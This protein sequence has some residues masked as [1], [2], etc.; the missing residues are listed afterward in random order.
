[1]KT[2][3]RPFN[4]LQSCQK[5]IRDLGFLFSFN[6]SVLCSVWVSSGRRKTVAETLGII[7]MFQIGRKGKG[8]GQNMAV[9][10]FCHF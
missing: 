1:M 6:L 3:N 7:S 10:V 4:T 9:L 5:F 2:R 8:K